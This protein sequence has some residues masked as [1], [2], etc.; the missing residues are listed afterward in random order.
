MIKIENILNQIQVIPL[1]ILIYFIVINLI[2]FIIT[3][4][5][6]HAAIH[7]KWRIPEKK[8]IIFSVIGG[9]IGVLLAFY[10]IRHKTKHYKLLFLVWSITVVITVLFVFI[11]VK[12]L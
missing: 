8:F 2:A 6:K 10:S 11:F 7:S 9:G 3:V 12:Q 4:Y 5:D 1:L